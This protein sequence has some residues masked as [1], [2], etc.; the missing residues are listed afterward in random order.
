[1]HVAG[2]ALQ[3]NPYTVPDMCATHVRQGQ[4]RGDVFVFVRL[5][6]GLQQ[7]P[8]VRLRKCEVNGDDLIDR[9]DVVAVDL[10]NQ[11]QREQDQERKEHTRDHGWLYFR[12]KTANVANGCAR[13]E[14][15]VA[16]DAGYV[17]LGMILNHLGLG[18]VVPA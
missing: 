11:P 6:V 10:A 16:Q 7:R 15:S 8:K 9:E 12:Y 5:V 1:M 14:D 2:I 17:L 18:G 3:P 13:S 4:M